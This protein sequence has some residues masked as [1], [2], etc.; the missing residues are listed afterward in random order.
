MKEDVGFDDL[1]ERKR[2][3][4]KKDSAIQINLQD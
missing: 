2:E 3:N 4:Y 1:D